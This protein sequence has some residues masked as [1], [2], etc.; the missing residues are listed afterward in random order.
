ML[1]WIIL[2]LGDSILQCKMLMQRADSLEKT[3]ILG[4]IGGKRRRRWQ[5]MRWLDSITDSM[6]MN[7]SKL[8]EV[9]EDKGAWLAAVHGITKSRT[10]LN[11]WTIAT[12]RSLGV[13]KCSSPQPDLVNQNCPQILPYVL[14]ITKSLLVG[15]HC[16]PETY[17]PQV[18]DG[19]DQESIRFQIPL[20]A[21][22]GSRCWSLPSGFSFPSSSA[23]TWGL[24]PRPSSR[25]GHPWVLFPLLVRLPHGH[26]CFHSFHSSAT[27]FFSSSLE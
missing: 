16:P 22:T 1:D 26:C 17:L 19:Q 2:Y 15:N 13:D 25:W 10:Q 18:T 11:N 20:T 5:R 9:V 24:F 8:W 4:K 27:F 7:P 12:G 6:D 23:F 14:W 21:G 3:L